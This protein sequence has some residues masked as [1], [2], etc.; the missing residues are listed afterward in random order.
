MCILLFIEFLHL[1][2]LSICLEL[3]EILIALVFAA[4]CVIFNFFC[5][6]VYCTSSRIF[7][8]LHF[9]HRFNNSIISVSN[10]SKVKEPLS[11]SEP[12]H[13]AHLLNRS[14]PAR[15]DECQCTGNW[16]RVSHRIVRYLPQTQG[17]LLIHNSSAEWTEATMHEWL[18]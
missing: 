17:L 4:F 8:L 12:W 3:Y 13:G 11:Y 16:T 6:N 1:Y 2:L 7:T 10:I 14:E 18:A 5:W 15:H 9:L